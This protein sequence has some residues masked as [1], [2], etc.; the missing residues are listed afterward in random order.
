MTD[1]DGGG[2]TDAERNADWPDAG[3]APG[4]PPTAL[5]G[6]SEGQSD[7]KPAG[8]ASTSNQEAS[9]PVQTGEERGHS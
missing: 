7:R 4:R 2:R 8:G 9:N 6:S 1:R 3:G 5:G